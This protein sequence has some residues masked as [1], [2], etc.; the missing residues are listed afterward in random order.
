MNFNTAT[1]RSSVK[2]EKCRKK[3]F[4]YITPNLYE[5]SIAMKSENGRFINK[6]EVITHQP[7]PGRVTMVCPFDQ[8]G[9]EL[10]PEPQDSLLWLDIK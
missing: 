4:F 1:S 7:P 10:A 8:V 6:A 9:F 3:I 2:L 5:L